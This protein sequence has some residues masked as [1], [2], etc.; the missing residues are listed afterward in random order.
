VLPSLSVRS[1]FDLLLGALELPP[2]S[3]VLCTPINIDGMVAVARAHRLR[4][5]PV[6]IDTGTLLPSVAELAGKVTERTRMLLVASVFGAAVPLKPLVPLCKKHGLVLVSDAAESFTSL[7]GAAGEEEEVADVTFYS[8]GTIKT[9]SCVGG[10]VA[11][12]KS[13]EIAAEMGRLQGAYVQRAACE[14]SERKE[15]RVA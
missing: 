9:S 10:G 13:A 2:G 11:V 12:I 3:E 4:M 8:F 5:V 15:E 14:R 6:D 7:S 1:S